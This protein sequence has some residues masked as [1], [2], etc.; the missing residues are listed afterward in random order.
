[1][2]NDNSE[3]FDKIFKGNIRNP[4]EFIII[5]AFLGLFFLAFCFLPSLIMSE[6]IRLQ[7]KDCEWIELSNGSAYQKDNH[8]AVY[9]NEEEEYFLCRNVTYIL[10]QKEITRTISDINKATEICILVPKKQLLNHG[11]RNFMDIRALTVNK[12]LLISMDD[13]S[14]MLRI[15]VK[16]IT[17]IPTIIFILYCLF[18]CFFC[19]IARNADR[20]PRVLTILVKRNRIK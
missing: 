16:K 12:K 9:C 6:N 3:Q 19:Y 5:F 20:Y 18:V 17:T 7:E 2:I 1:M 14:Q 13:T 8:I 10:D 11:D 15:E 4:L